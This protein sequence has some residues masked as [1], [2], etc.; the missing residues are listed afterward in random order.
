MCVLRR[1]TSPHADASAQSCP[2]VGDDTLHAPLP[3]YSIPD[4]AASP[5]PAVADSA[6]IDL[7]FVDFI[8]T[9]A[10]RLL[11]QVQN[12][13]IFVDADVKSYSDLLIYE[14]LSSYAQI[15]WN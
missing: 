6:L 12:A 2:G 15:A 5:M 10:V 7:V 13:T 11:N 9:D 4:Y 14:V 1:P 3:Y 8:G